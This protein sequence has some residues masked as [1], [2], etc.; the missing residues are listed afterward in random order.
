MDNE[1][2]E[3]VEW[4]EVTSLPVVGGNNQV[5]NTS[6]K[7]EIIQAFEEV[8]LSDKY[9]ATVLKD[10]ID[11]AITANPKTGEYYE[12]YSTKLS[13]IRA[14]HKMKTWA[15]DVSIQIANIF[16]GWNVL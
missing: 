9:L 2:R 1:N 15:P 13:A 12:D 16:P 4:V 11:N 3:E 7:S 14:Y 10:I 8:W 5:A 6:D